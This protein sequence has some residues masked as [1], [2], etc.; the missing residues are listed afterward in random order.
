[1][2][3]QQLMKQ[4][5][6][7]QKDFSKKKDEFDL[8]NFDFEYQSG[9]I[10]ISISGKLEIKKILINKDLID[11]NDAETLEDVLRNAINDSIAKISAKREELMPKIPGLS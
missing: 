6:K 1:M 7:M 11:P 2:N 5:Q 3:I 8:Q 4:A 9:L 10:K